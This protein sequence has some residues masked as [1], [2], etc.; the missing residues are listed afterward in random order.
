MFFGF[1]QG[2]LS[3]VI[4]LDGLILLEIIW[5]RNILDLMLFF[6]TRLGKLLT[7]AYIVKQDIRRCSA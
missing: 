6:K 7:K 3:L 2:I 1:C 4:S 5:Q